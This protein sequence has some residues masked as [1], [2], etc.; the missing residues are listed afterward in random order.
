MQTF[1]SAHSCDGFA[2]K[3]D[4]SGLWQNMLKTVHGCAGSRWIPKH[5]RSLEVLTS[6]GGAAGL[7]TR[8]RRSGWRHLVRGLGR[9]CQDWLRAQLTLTSGLRRFAQCFCCR[10]QEWVATAP[11]PHSWQKVREREIFQIASW[12]LGRKV[13]FGG[14]IMSNSFSYSRL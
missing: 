8:R 1:V 11:S 13:W 14:G 10:H 3:T 6:G 5:H 9:H 2:M 4:R 7:G 12:L